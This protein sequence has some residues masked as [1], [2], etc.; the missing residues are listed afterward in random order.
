MALRRFWAWLGDDSN[1][2][3]INFFWGVS[4]VFFGG[5]S[6]IGYWAY[7]TYLEGASQ[8]DVIISPNGETAE[9]TEVQLRTSLLLYEYGVLRREAGDLESAVRSF[10]AALTLI[11][12]EDPN[13]KLHYQT[14]LLSQIHVYREMGADELFEV[15]SQTYERLFLLE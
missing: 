5:L 14:V 6:G 12:A 15:S 11:D 3:R 9:P 7:Q 10:D 2:K 4:L 1:L 13:Q 8:R